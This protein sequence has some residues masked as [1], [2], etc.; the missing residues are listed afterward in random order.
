MNYTTKAS[1]Q[2]RV[3]GDLYITVKDADG[4]AVDYLYFTNKIVSAPFRRLT[5]SLIGEANSTVL[6]ITHLG[7]GQGSTP[8]DFYLHPSPSWGGPLENMS[9]VV[10]L[11]GSGRLSATKVFFAWVLG[12]G[13][14]NDHPIREFA[15]LYATGASQ[16]DLFSR[17]VRLDIQKTDKLIFEGT[18]VLEFLPS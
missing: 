10:A 18:W 15:L 12:T 5:G 4:N 17:I 8:T 13:E 7:W 2:C 9:G 14:A 11:K 1:D 16:Y 3:K 6:P